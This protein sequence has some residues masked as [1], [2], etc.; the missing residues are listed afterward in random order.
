MRVRGRQTRTSA[1]AVALVVLATTGCLGSRH[2]LGDVC[3]PAT[4]RPLGD[5]ERIGTNDPAALL[6]RFAGHWSGT[7]TWRTGGATGLDIDVP[8]DP[9]GPFSVYIMCGVVSA[10]FVERP[11]ALTT[12]D[13]AL[14]DVSALF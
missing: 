1:A 14:D 7:L 3:G 11:A 6:A 4:T 12:T 8:A 13:G 10:V 5:G 9:A 2:D